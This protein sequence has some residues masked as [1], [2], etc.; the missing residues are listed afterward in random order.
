[1]V[2]THENTDT[3][4]IHSSSHKS[5]LPISFIDFIIEDSIADI[6]PVTTQRGLYS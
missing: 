3:F 4:T 2:H 1:M 6:T 5:S